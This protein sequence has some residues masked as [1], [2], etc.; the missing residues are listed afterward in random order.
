[1][2]PTSAGC[3]LAAPAPT[4]ANPGGYSPP[5]SLSERREAHHDDDK[6]KGAVEVLMNVRL[7]EIASRIYRVSVYIPEADFMFN[8]F[9]VDGDEP[10]LF[11]TRPR[12]LFPI[13][14]QALNQVRGG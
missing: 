3:F 14:S 5:R 8:Q 12:R 6:A 10:L 2:P 1:M 4:V 9:L 7:D 11:H 13:V